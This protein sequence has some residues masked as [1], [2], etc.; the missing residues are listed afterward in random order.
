MGAR[1]EDYERAAPYKSFLHVDQFPG[2]KQLAEF[3]HQLDK[4]DNKYNEYFQ[5]RSLSTYI[6][7]FL[8][9]A[10]KFYVLFTNVSA[11]SNKP[12]IY[13]S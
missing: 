9:H 6:L 12:V 5:V 3:L 13:V 2:P 11:F 8:R 1:L 10:G 4:D 7:F